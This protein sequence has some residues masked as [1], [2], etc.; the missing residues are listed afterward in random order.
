MRPRTRF[1]LVT[2]FA[3]AGLIGVSPATASE[4]R[5]PVSWPQ[6]GYDQ[7]H[8]SVNPLE[9][10]LG[11]S[12]A[13]QLTLKWRNNT[14]QSASSPVEADGMLFVATWNNNTLT[15]LDSAT[16]ATLWSFARSGSPSINTPA[17]ANGLVF[18]SIGD[19]IYSLDEAT[20]AQRWRKIISTPG[21][22]VT[23]TTN[24]PTTTLYVVGGYTI[25]AID[26]ATGHVFWMQ[27][28]TPHLSIQAAPTVGNGLVYVADDNLVLHAYDAATGVEAWELTLPTRRGLVPTDVALDGNLI[29]LG[30]IGDR[31]YAVDATTHS[32][33]WYRSTPVV[34]DLAVANGM[35]YVE[36]T[37]VYPSPIRLQA[38]NEADG[39]PLWR[40]KVNN[41]SVGG[42]DE[43]PTVA[44]GVV[45][46]TSVEG[47][48]AAF[49]AATGGPL[50]WDLTTDVCQANPAVV[51]AAVYVSC[52]GGA[53]AFG[54]PS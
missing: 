23:V 44:N 21:I 48:V 36:T 52:T 54:L 34:S 10:V 3:L 15:A 42:F 14:G 51:N 13:S 5:S 31:L 24:G 26:G 19:Y 43:G 9:T 4:G 38:F 1:G 22:S 35:I 18:V 2:L 20:G 40:T 17:V 47:G 11:T 27:S 45:Y 41:G 50:W 29:L 30:S 53:F 46:A 12:N 39:T 37:G 7:T 33:L 16:G 49:D 8:L 6:R 25:Y 28:P 32:F